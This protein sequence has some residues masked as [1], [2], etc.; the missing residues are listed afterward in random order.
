MYLFICLFI[1]ATHVAYGCFRP[2]I[3]SNLYCVAATYPTAVATPEP[4]IHCMRLG[5]K[6]ASAT[7]Q[8]AAVGFFF[9]FNLYFFN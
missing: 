4:L 7:A 3:E 6:T 5:I 2:G 1:T 8:A 9:F